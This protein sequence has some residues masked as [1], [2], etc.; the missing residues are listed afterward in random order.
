MVIIT[1]FVIGE[2]VIEY[3]NDD[4]VIDLLS[5]NQS[6]DSGPM[7]TLGSEFQLNTYSAG[8]QKFVM[9]SGQPK[10]SDNTGGASSK[11]APLP[12]GK[13]VVTWTSDGQD[14]SGTGVYAQIFNSDATKSN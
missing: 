4:G 6:F 9:T 8:N 7:T 1:D 13:F 5:L 14:G 2:D 10:G 12:E 3:F 11:I